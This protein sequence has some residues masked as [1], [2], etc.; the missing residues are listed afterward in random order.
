MR[1]L[2]QV[3]RHGFVAVTAAEM[4]ADDARRDAEGLPYRF[5]LP[6]ELALTPDNSG[7]WEDLPDGRS[8]WRLRLASPGVLSLNLGFSRLDLP[9]GARL[10]VYPAADPDRARRCDD[11]DNGGHQQLW[12]PV[13]L[14]DELV[15]ELLVHSPER[16]L[17]TLEVG[18]IGRGYRLF[19]AE[20]SAKS[21]SCNVDVVCPEGD[22]WRDDID[23][24]GLLQ[25]DGSVV[26][27]G[28]LVNN[29]A[30]DG[31]PLFMT[32]DHCNLDEDSAP[33]LVVYW[34][35]Q[36][37]TCGQQGGGQLMQTSSGSTLLATSET[38]DF[39][40]VELDQVPD[41]DFGV[42]YAGWS[43]VDAA[44][45]GAVCIHH[46]RGDEKSISFEDDA[47]EITTYLNNIVPGN[48]THLRVVDWDLGTTEPGSSGSPLFDPEHRVV[49]QLHGGNAACGN[50]LSDWYGR[51][52]ISWTGDGT[53]A[54]RLSDH[55]DAAGTGALTVDLYDPLAARFAVTP[56]EG[57]E[58]T[59]VAG[60][61]FSP[62]EHLFT[63]VNNG[64]ASV[65]FTAN[66]SVAW[67]ALDNTGETLA[68][69]GQTEVT[70][71]LTAAAQTLP[72]GI[73]RAVI[74]FTNDSSGGSPTIRTVVLTVT[75]NALS[76]L[77]PAPNPFTTAPVSIRYTLRGQTTVR[78]T[79][80][81]LRG[82]KVRD[83][84]KF[85]GAPGENAIPWDGRDDQGQRVPSGVYIVAVK[86][87][88]HTFRVNVTYAH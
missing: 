72:V 85:S 53:P 57:A 27:T 81:N 62:L 76:V 9:V 65:A 31:R 48:G 54:T 16:P 86:G 78:A 58:A 52:A 13:F 34:N 46:P 23:T 10:L 79:V 36:S 74:T 11:E 30:A 88:G 80:T 60:G 26:C 69:G 37:S 43:R 55:L 44:P 82:F 18:S 3:E 47:T 8:L 70:A 68:V 39:T 28:F 42:K 21:G 19:G 32:A 15:V 83:L 87:L 63:V 71:T 22:D 49:G 61:P 45:A 75:P 35:F 14:C 59:G 4:A 84:G 66:S 20:E 17:V 24:V 67:L 5:A 7:T 1:P 56:A 64:T 40:L 29:T 77:G 25:R 6:V 12:T 51:F 41:P 33:T 50:D 73:H 2:A 38:S